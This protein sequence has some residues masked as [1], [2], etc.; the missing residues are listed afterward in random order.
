VWLLVQAQRLGASE[1]EIL[2]AYPTLRASDLVNAWAYV[3][4]FR[5]E[6]A[7]QIVENESA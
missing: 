4:A 6:I 2:R 5:D 1:A 3:R 7:A